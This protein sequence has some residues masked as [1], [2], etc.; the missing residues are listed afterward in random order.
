MP[1]TD[2]YYDPAAPRANSIVVAVAAAVRN[3]AGELLL[4]E[5]SDNHLWALPGGAQDIGETVTE[6]CI[7]EVKEETGLD[8]E[9]I[10]LS[11]IYSDPNH[12]IAYDDGEVRQEFSICFHAKPTGGTIRTSSE[13]RT[14]HWV[15]PEKLDSLSIHPSMLLRIEHALSGRS[16]P[17][18]P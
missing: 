1:K 13:S 16:T 9:I 8:V 4:I 2:Y 11:G 18:L 3:D 7:R 14:V 15:S 12:V 6:A 10:G 5:R 17:Y